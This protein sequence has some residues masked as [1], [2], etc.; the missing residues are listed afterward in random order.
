MSIRCEILRIKCICLC[1][2]VMCLCIVGESQGLKLAAATC[3]KN[4]TRQYM[5]AKPSSSELHREFR[6]Q[7]AQTVL[8]AER[9]IL[10]VLAEAV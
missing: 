5:E 7:L 4:F 2:R 1:L 3:L 9:A 8:Q 6:N 10:K